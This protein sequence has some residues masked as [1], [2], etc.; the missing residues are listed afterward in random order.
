MP[1]RRLAVLL[2]A[3]ALF[4]TACRNEDNTDV[5]VENQD[6][7]IATASSTDDPQQMSES[8]LVESIV[9]GRLV[10]TTGAFARLTVNGSG[11]LGDTVSDTD[12]SVDMALRIEAIEG[13]DVAFFKVLVNCDE[14][15]TAATTAPSEVVKF[16]GTVTVPVTSD[17]HVVVMGFGTQSMPRG[18][19]NVNAATT[20]RFI[21]NPF[22][23]DADGD[24]SFTPPGG[25][26]CA[27]TLQGP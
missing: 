7:I 13:I 21:T 25:K 11:G 2:L 20:A 8:E 24:G 3:V 18:F 14:V 19:P 1:L 15:V 22:F 23:V 9:G 6:R 4:T 12:G 10:V 27:Y 17:A 5:P 16:D 26:T